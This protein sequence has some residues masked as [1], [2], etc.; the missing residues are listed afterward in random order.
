MGIDY[1][2]NAHKLPDSANIKI[3]Y[4]SSVALFALNYTLP[5]SVI[6]S[7]ITTILSLIKRNELLALNAI[8]YS[9]KSVSSI[10]FFISLLATLS[11][12]ALNSTSFAY[13]KERIDNIQDN[14]TT[15]TSKENFFVK[16]QNS[17]IYFERLYPLFQRAE[18][19]RIY[20]L[21]NGNLKRII[22][23]DRAFYR[24]D[25]WILESP[26]I[27]KKPDTLELGGE[28]LDVQNA[29][30]L[31]TLRGFKPKI[32]DNVYE[33]RGVLSIIDAIESIKLLNI[34]GINT[35]KIRS[36]LYSLL[37]FPLFAPLFGLVI[38]R[39]APL[40]SRYENLSLLAFKA[41]MLALSSWGLFF[42]LSKLSTSG[43]INPEVS[44]L[45]P[46]VLMMAF[47]IYSYNKS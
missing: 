20:E 41:I 19:I 16:Y 35:D 45:L 32:L 14:G 6:L 31:E 17:Y 23:S 11:L 46:L 10:I 27:I 38:C 28:G 24:D 18:V 13:A 12:I 30:R 22:K 34:E 8:G 5:L 44:I 7:Q 39:F 4:S 2:S 47:S 15:V 43:L 33:T 42:A 25:F 9:K 37:M 36:V 29:D 21:E 40:Q 3:I 1:L 26:T